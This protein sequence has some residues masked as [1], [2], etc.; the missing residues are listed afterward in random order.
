MNF[1]KCRSASASCVD[2]VR[3]LPHFQALGYEV[4]E[5]KAAEDEWA[6]TSTLTFAA[7]GDLNTVVRQVA[8]VIVM[9]DECGDSHRCVGTLNTLEAFTGENID[10]NYDV[11]SRIENMLREM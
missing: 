4:I 3:L 8:K 10:E 11:L 6:E 5:M 9:H 2:I 1:F 7:D